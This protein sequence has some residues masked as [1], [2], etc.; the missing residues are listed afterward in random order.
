MKRASAARGG[1]AMAN[2]LRSLGQLAG[3]AGQA[4]QGYG[5]DRENAVKRAM[6]EAREKREAE[7][8]QI[9]NAL[10]AAQTAQIGKPVRRDFIPVPRGGGLF[11]PEKGVMA[12]EP[13]DV[14]DMPQTVAPGVGVRQ[15]DGS[16]MVPIA[17]SNEMTPY[18][19]RSL[20]LREQGLADA[21]TRQQQGGVQSARIQQTYKKQAQTLDNLDDAIKTYRTQLEK[22]GIEV[23][24]GEDK[25]ML[26]GAYAN[27]KLLAKEAANLGALTGPDV[28]ILEELFNDP[29]TIGSGMLNIV[30]GGQRAKGLLK[31]LDQYES[32]IKGNRSRL[33]QNYQSVAPNGGEVGEPSGTRAQQLWDAAVAKHGREKVLADFGP[34]P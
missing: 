31:Q 2:F 7:N 34:R 22:S 25:S 15:P 28:K 10:M 8:D 13:T 33:E 1:N 21:R 5:I 19:Q 12:V 30:Q 9:R 24:P 20:D 17:K 14:P 16:Y 29:A 11:D 26:T 27:L 18:E 23:M 32:I 3:V 4:V 6:L